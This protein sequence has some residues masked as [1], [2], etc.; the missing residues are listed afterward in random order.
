VLGRL[1]ILD[2]ADD[3]ELDGEEIRFLARVSPVGGP[4]ISDERRLIVTPHPLN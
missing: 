1:A 4:E 2:I 3:S